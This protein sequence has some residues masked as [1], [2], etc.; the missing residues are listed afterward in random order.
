MAHRQCKACLSACSTS[1][2][3]CMHS[4]AAAKA[5]LEAK[6]VLKEDVQ[7]AICNTISMAKDVSA[8]PKQKL[9]AQRRFFCRYPALDSGQPSDPR[10]ISQPDP[11]AVAAAPRQ[12]S[13][14]TGYLCHSAHLRYLS[15][16]FPRHQR[17]HHHA[18]GTDHSCSRRLSAGFR[19]D[20]R[21]HSRHSMAE[22]APL[23]CSSSTFLDWILLLYQQSQQQV[24][25]CFSCTAGCTDS[26]L[27]LQTCNESAVCDTSGLHARNQACISF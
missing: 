17:T 5:H 9:G 15:L 6:K 19:P 10:P 26:V 13:N 3:A 25:P 20:C 1:L 11:E 8:N 27:I 2:S 21:Q 24:L 12:C 23:G 14:A 18:T 7:H 22:A 4:K 16:C